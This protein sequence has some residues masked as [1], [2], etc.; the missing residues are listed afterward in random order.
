MKK[1][2]AT[3]GFIILAALYPSLSSAD[4][5]VAL[6]LERTEASMVDTIQMEVRVSGVRNSDTTPILHGLEEFLV[7]SGGTSSRI[8]IIN[9]KVSAGLTYTYFIQPQ[10]TGTFEIGPAEMNV[11]GEKMDSNT[12][13]LVVKAAAE[14]NGTDR[15]PVFL[16]ASIASPDVYVEEQVLYILKLYRRVN[17][18]NLTLSLPQLEHIAFKQLGKPRDYQATVTGTTYYVLEVRYSLS[19]SKEGAY[20]I[21]PSKMNMTV[22]GRRSQSLLDDFF[23]DSFSH[24]PFS[25]FS[26]GRPL[27]VAA[28]PLELNVLALPQEERPTDFSGLVGSF[29]MESNLQPSR[30]RAGESATLTVQ[31]NGKGNINRIPDIDL[32]ELPFARSYNDQPLLETQSDEQGIGGRKTMKWALVPQK[33]GQFEIP[34]LRLSFFNPDTEKYD[35][36]QTSVHTLSVLPGTNQA[37]AAVQTSPSNAATAETSVKKEIKKIGN[38]ILPIHMSAG[39]LSVPYKALSRGWLFWLVLFGPFSSYLLLWGGT[40][41]R[42][43]SPQRTARSRSKNAFRKFS[44]QCRQDI[45]GCADLMDAFRDYLNGRFNLS[46]GTLT[47]D[48]T[49]KLLREKGVATDTADQIRTLIQRLENAVY[50]GDDTKPLDTT[51]DLLGLVKTL[52]KECQ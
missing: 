4:V 23:K 30:L 33:T 38:D 26:S 44:K 41:L 42:R 8:E 34:S 25:T 10:K 32:P 13:K 37:S 45:A 52:E 29:R 36:L 12:V 48:E 21:G 50:A 24:S 7:R 17:V 46:I 47:P 40:K 15:T 49:E 39:D 22:R 31:I 9:G 18:N 16:E 27:T 2:A 28:D 14:R 35:V 1:I 51:D 11:D 19:A 6:Q 20:L 5:N 3:I 43:R